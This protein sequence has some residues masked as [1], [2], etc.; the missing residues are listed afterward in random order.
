M[1]RMEEYEALLQE[2]DQPV[3]ALEQTLERAKK[4]RFRRRNVL[5]PVMGA[6]AAFLLFVLLVNFSAP[7]AYAC[8]QVPILRELAQAV[9]FSPSLTDAVENE[10]VQPMNLAQTDGDVSAKIEY[11]I[12]D[13]KQ[14]NVFYR[15]YSDIYTQMNAEP[16][17]LNGEGGFLGSCS[18]GPNDWDVPNG[19]LQSI[20]IDFVENDVPGSL[21]L[22]L[23]I[24]DHSTQNE[25]EAPLNTEEQL[26]N[27]TAPEETEYVAHFDFL[28]EFDPKFT[29]A[30]KEFVVNQTVELEGQKIT[31]TDVEVYPSH[32][33]V[34][35]ADE[36][37]NTAWLKRLDFYIETDYGMKFETVSEGV[38]A[39]GSDGDGSFESFR[40]ESSYFYEAETLKIMITG[41]EWLRKDM[42][43]IYIN[44]ETGETSGLPEGVT[45]HSAK[46]LNSGWILQLKGIQRKENHFH[47]I[48]GHKFYDE[49]GNE[50]EIRS[51]SCYNAD[52]EE[53]KNGVMYMIEEVP[54]ANY[55]DT[56]VWVAP[57]YSHEWFAEEPVTVEIQ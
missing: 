2:L 8:S 21:R 36:S 26:F 45:F 23:S 29:A 17:V 33:R 55:Y 7:I 10:Y 51:R 44:L 13:Q 35:V 48:L 39:T 42:E 14:I 30:G 56:E 53:N 12:V 9:T 16:K 54:L 50:Y 5:R 31:I 37:D 38:T 28:L 19:E 27:P 49:A 32:M 15:L 41:A 47:Q 57:N 52:Q 3:P 20:T 46:K 24:I 34:N 22:Q 6:A 40:A 43:K 18:Y 4:K 25:N 1:N 11:L